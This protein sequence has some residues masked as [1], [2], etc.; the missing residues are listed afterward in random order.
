MEESKKGALDV[1]AADEIHRYF[2]AKQAV[3]DDEALLKSVQE[4][5]ENTAKLMVLLQK[6]S[7]DAKE[8]VSLSNDV[9]AM[10]ALLEKEPKIIELKEAHRIMMAY[11]ESVKGKVSFSCSGNCGE[12]ASGCKDKEEEKA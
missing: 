6:E 12:C 5:E 11:V 7:Y 3:N 4:Y 2:K 8:A 10:S 9:E 1:L